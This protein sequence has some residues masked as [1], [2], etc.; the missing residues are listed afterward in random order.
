MY[1]EEN[2]G[3]RRFIA[4]HIVKDN[5]GFFTL[6]DAKEI[7]KTKD[8]NANRVN[9]L[10]VDLQKHLGV[11]CV[12]CKKVKGKVYRNVFVGYSISFGDDSIDFLD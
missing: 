11:E 5:E 4:E 12:S 9:Q 1:L 3:V 10:K 6:A 2:D 7:Y 8:Y